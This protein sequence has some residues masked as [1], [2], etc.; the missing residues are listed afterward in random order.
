MNYGSSAQ[1]MEIPGNFVRVT[2][3]KFK[4]VSDHV[5]YLRTH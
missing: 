2:D 4:Q 5:F 3:K 1:I